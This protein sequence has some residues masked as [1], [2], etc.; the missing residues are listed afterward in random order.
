[1]PDTVGMQ[2]VV[3]WEETVGGACTNRRPSE[4]VRHRIGTQGLCGHIPN[5]STDK[6]VYI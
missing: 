4:L 2:Q 6:H 5:F 3:A 1:V